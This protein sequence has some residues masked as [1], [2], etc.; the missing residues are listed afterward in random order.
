MIS[1]ESALPKFG[2]DGIHVRQR[3][4]D[5]FRSEGVYL[6]NISVH[7]GRT[8]FQIKWEHLGLSQETIKALKENNA[9]PTRIKFFNS[10]QR[11]LNKLGYQRKEIQSKLMVYR[12][13]YWFVPESK[14]EDLADAVASLKQTASLYKN[15]VLLDYELEKQ[16]YLTVVDKILRTTPLSGE[17]QESVQ[18]IYLSLFP[19]QQQI[20]S[21]FY[22]ELFGPIR[23][24]SIKEQS[25][26]DAELAEFEVRNFQAKALI[27]LETQFHRGLQTKLSEVVQSASDEFCGILAENLTLLEQLGRQDLPDRRK[28]QLLEAVER[29]QNLVCFEKSLGDVAEQFTAIASRARSHNYIEMSEAIAQLKGDLTREYHLIA[30][31]GKGHR[32]L[33]EWLSV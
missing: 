5:T 20:G 8:S 25:Q 31:S 28:S 13:P 2:V 16:K 21:S 18:K 33:A 1:V 4:L 22:I 7:G 11:K 10:L 30:P 9:Q 29:C 24:P 3:H 14:F 17:T 12:D 23:V 27:E 19:T 6:F 15:E 26:M 32:A